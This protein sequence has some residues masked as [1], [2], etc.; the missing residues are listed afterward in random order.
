V[1]ELSRFLGIDV[2]VDIY[3]FNVC[4]DGILR[5]EDGWLAFSETP[6]WRYPTGHRRPRLTPFGPTELPDDADLI[7]LGR[8]ELMVQVWRDR[9]RPEGCSPSSRWLLTAPIEELMRLGPQRELD[10]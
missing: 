8:G 3:P 10:F 7:L 1:R 2:H 6:G 5:I 4:A 9:P